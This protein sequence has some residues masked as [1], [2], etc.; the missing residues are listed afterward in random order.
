MSADSPD[1]FEPSAQQKAKQ[2]KSALKRI[3]IFIFIGAG[4]IFTLVATSILN[5]GK[6][7][8]G[9]NAPVNLFEASAGRNLL[10][11]LVLNLLSLNLSR[12]PFVRLI[13]PYLKFLTS[14]NK[15]K[16]N[17]FSPLMLLPT[18]RL[19]GNKAIMEVRFRLAITLTLS[20]KFQDC[21][22]MLR[23]IL[24]ILPLISQCPLCLNSRTPICNMTAQ[25]SENVFDTVTGRYLLIPRGARLIV[26]Y[27]NQISYGQSRILVMCSRLIFPDGSSLVLDNLKDA[28][29]SGYSGFKS[30]VNRHCGYHFVCPLCI[31][32]R[33]RC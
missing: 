4:I 33:R 24:L 12:T 21:C 1:R 31:I 17:D 10:L 8:N 7:V 23:L 18:F 25:V 13:F 11:L 9:S 2:D 14:E 20:L 19:S 32:A 28:D 6:G 16:Y 26:T 22:P 3:A 15:I 5:S 27:D 30:A 29:Q